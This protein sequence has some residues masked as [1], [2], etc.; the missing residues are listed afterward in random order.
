MFDWFGKLDTAPDERGVLKIMSR[1]VRDAE[2][3]ECSPFSKGSNQIGTLCRQTGGGGRHW[4]GAGRPFLKKGNREGRLR[5]ELVKIARRKD[6]RPR[7]GGLEF[8]EDGL[9]LGSGFFFCKRAGAGF[10]RLFGIIPGLA[11]GEA[12]GGD[13]L[14]AVS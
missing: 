10:F 8:R 14:R 12:T 4:Q 13:F 3:R 9:V 6:G 2:A 5:E 1:K 7:L 11:G